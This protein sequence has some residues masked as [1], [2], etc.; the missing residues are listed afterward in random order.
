VTIIDKISMLLLSG[1]AVFFPVLAGPRRLLNFIS[2]AMNFGILTLRK[3][4]TSVHFSREHTRWHARNSAHMH[5]DDATW[6]RSLEDSFVQN[7]YWSFG[8]IAGLIFVNTLII[9]TCQ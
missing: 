3:R 8:K 5:L 7:A 1:H 2:G 6:F 4:I 9:I